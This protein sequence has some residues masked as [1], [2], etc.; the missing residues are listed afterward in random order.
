MV[1]I[2]FVSPATQEFVSKK[3]FYKKGYK[4]K[5]LL[6]KKLVKLRHRDLSEN[7]HL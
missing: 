3:L 5:V 6:L 1:K 7:S 2:D 4:V